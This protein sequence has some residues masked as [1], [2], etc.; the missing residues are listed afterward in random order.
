MDQAAIERIL[1]RLCISHGGEARHVE[2][3]TFVIELPVTLGDAEQEGGPT[4]SFRETFTLAEGRVTRVEHEASK[5]H[6]EVVSGFQE[7]LTVALRREG[8]TF[9]KF[10]EVVAFLT[11]EI[12]AEVDGDVVVVQP[13]GDD[14]EEITVSCVHVARE[15]WVSV[16]TPFA[17][18]LDLDPAWLLEQNSE[19]THVHFE[20]FEGQPSLAGAFPLHGLTAERLLELLD[21]LVSFRE[22]FLAEIEAGGED[23][24]E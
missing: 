9:S 6:P 22:S 18:D 8:R 10:E 11:E 2:G 15:P 17:S 21:D 12:E 7:D 24:D 13:D 20:T 4:L 3:L 5:A 19:L 14:A 23:E 16:S 1:H